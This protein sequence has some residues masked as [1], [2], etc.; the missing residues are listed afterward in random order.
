MHN[1]EKVMIDCCLYRY[2]L[3]LSDIL[4]LVGTYMTF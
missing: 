1:E 4:V 2:I 3:A